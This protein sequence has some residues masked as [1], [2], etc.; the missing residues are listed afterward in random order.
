MRPKIMKACFSQILFWNCL[1]LIIQKDT[2]D[3]LSVITISL[4]ELFSYVEVD[5][6]NLHIKDCL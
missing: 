6:A 1:C 2:T 5:I 4:I 3:P